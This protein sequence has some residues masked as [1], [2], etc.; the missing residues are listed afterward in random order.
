M[1][2]KSPQSRQENAVPRQRKHLADS[3]TAHP[4]SSSAHRLHQHPSIH[5]CTSVGADLWFWSSSVQPLAAWTRLCV[6]RCRI[7]SWYHTTRSVPGFPY[8]AHR[9]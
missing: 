8:D 4:T 1:A 6:L 3:M 9:T 5:N 7:N 2:A